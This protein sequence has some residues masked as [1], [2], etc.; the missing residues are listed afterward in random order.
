MVELASLEGENTRKDIG[1]RLLGVI[2]GEAEPGGCR[3]NVLVRRNESV[4]RIIW[5]CATHLDMTEGEARYSIARVDECVDEA[6]A[7]KEGIS[8]QLGGHL[9]RNGE[10]HQRTESLGSVTQGVAKP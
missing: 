7:A 1:S 3:A 8:N 10:A 2:V 5:A 9:N 4:W 6:A